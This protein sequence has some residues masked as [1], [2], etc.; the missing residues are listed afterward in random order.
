MDLKFSSGNESLDKVLGG[1]RQG[2][3]CVWQIDHIEHYR[4]FVNAFVRQAAADGKEIVY[5]RFAPHE[6]LIP[7]EVKVVEY[8]FSPEK[9]FENFL[10]GILDI[11]DKHG[12]GCCYV[13]D[14]LSDLA[15]DWNC[16]RLLGCFFML[17][18]P[19]LYKL[20]TV[21]YFGIIRNVHGPLATDIIHDTAQVVINIYAGKEHLYLQPIKVKNRYSPTLYMLH[22]CRN[23]VF[24]PETRSYVVSKIL[25]GIEQ[26]WLNFNIDRPGI[27][28][29]IIITAKR[30]HEQMQS[31]AGSL[32]P[33]GDSEALRKK[34]IRMMIT[35][36]ESVF[37][38][39][40]KFLELGDLLAI[41]KRMIGTGL[42][43]GKSVGML[44]AQSIMKKADPKWEVRLEPHDSFFI[45]SDVF[46]TYIIQN[47]CWWDL[48]RVKRS[49]GDFSAAAEFRRKIQ[50]GRFPKD[51]EERF[52]LMLNYYGQS[53]IIVRSSS[54]L[55]D[56]YGNAFSGKYESYFCVNRGTPEERMAS[57]VE[58][59]RN[60][61]ASTMN[62][63]A[64]AYR[65]HK[66]LLDKEERMG[67]LVQRVSGNFH[68]HSYFPQIAGVGY[69]FNPFAW[70]KRIDPSQG[71]LRLV[72]GLGTRAV[73]QHAG[74]H[75]RIVAINQ[76]LLRPE[77]GADQIG[78]YSQKIMDILD[79]NSNKVESVKF[80]EI[81]GNENIPA[82]SLFASRDEEMLERARQMNVKTVFPWILSFEKLLSATQF[83]H[84]MGEILKT[85][86]TAYRHP[87]DI[88]YSANFVNEEEYRIN[89]LQCR[90]FHFTGKA[91]ELVTPHDVRDEHIL[92]RT[93][94]PLLG[95]SKFDPVGKII[96]IE[97]EKYSS[98]SMQD[99]YAVA[100]LIGEITNY[101]T[102]DD[103]IML[104]G[105][106][107]WGTAMPALG[108]P[109][110]FNEIKHVSVLC[111]LALMHENLSPDISLGTHFFNDL[112]EMQI[113]YMS[114]NMASSGNLFNRH[115][116]T[117]AHNMLLD[118]FPASAAMVETVFV[119]D[120][121]AIKQD[122]ACYIHADTAKQKGMVFFMK[123]SKE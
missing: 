15:A 59:V 51:I 36:D 99:R 119:V 77:S 65:L 110:K 122:Y 47:D 64:L 71:V 81:A 63:N 3:N 88:E 29:N 95:Q 98:M 107:R 6:Y 16:D 58:A 118:I 31:G 111:E 76:P 90:P 109:V 33:G 5:F 26:P 24:M 42:I 121:A 82:L 28:T 41:A 123:G 86:E 37:A 87:V 10:I 80:S 9:G 83:V 103:N 19:H 97:S 20:D 55:E 61:Y 53:P 27:W 46:Y 117:G 113:M 66:G 108:I 93:C 44:L 49:T 74:D 114:M 57:F 1:I 32:L 48:R 101:F 106:G 52:K 11:I 85:L 91:K 30:L 94:D 12:I 50:E 92:L 112:V 21:A 105:P 4:Y 13:F 23:N 100:R 39:S 25:G 18:C 78:K 79:F 17:V 116:I 7:A 96:Y 73:E 68:E 2:D 22:I 70:N 56:A 89:I 72:F 120:A 43:G 62:E 54:L 69:S 115:Y 8:S 67:L 40:C 75:T 45:G 14:S 35:E 60:V 104:I 84:D 34:L 102:H 38:L